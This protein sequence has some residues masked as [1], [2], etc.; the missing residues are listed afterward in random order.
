VSF[1]AFEKA[2]MRHLAENV[3]LF[4]VALGIAFFYAIGAL[5][6]INIDQLVD[7]GLE[8]GQQS[9]SAKS[10]LLLALIAGVCLGSVLAGLWSGDHVDSICRWFAR[11]CF[12][13]RCSFLRYR[14][15]SLRWVPPSLVDLDGHAC[16]SFTRDDAGLFSVP[17][18]AYLQHRS[19]GSR[20]GVIM[21]RRTS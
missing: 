4:R 20:A 15:S 7:A 12:L 17:L 2:L 21:P 14:P 8:A 16:C 10:P 18:E 1:A 3:P 5:A 9:D 6:Q 19:R 11:S 13:S